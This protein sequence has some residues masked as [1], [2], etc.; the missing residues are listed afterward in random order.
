M[1]KKTEEDYLRVIY[2]FQEEQA[3]ELGVSSVDLCEY[4]GLSKSSVS[5]MLGKLAK[6]GLVKHSS[7]GKVTLTQK[8]LK[9]SVNV[10]KKHRIIE[11]FL[12]KVLRI[13]SKATHNEAHRLEHAFSDESISSIRKLIRNTGSCPHGKPIP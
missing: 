9:E 6:K 12:S 7:Y 2:H 1:I 13:K 4:L 5:E 8:G 10:T 11:V 3:S